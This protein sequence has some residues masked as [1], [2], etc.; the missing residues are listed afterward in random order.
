MIKLLGG[1][2]FGLTVG[3]LLQLIDKRLK[4][5]HVAEARI[6]GLT[7]SYELP[8]DLVQKIEIA[9]VHAIAFFKA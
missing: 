9:A 6:R 8:S 5:A 7:K 3:L 2:K 1:L 4:K